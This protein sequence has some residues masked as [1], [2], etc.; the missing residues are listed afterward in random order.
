MENRRNLS[1]LLNTGFEF[2]SFFSANMVKREHF[3]GVNE[4]FKIIKS[5]KDDIFEVGSGGGGGDSI[6]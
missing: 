4:T 5:L 6:I 1:F 3:P 2:Y